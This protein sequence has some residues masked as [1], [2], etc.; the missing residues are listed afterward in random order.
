MFR[1]LL[2]DVEEPSFMD[3]KK[4]EKMNV[5]IDGEQQPFLD[6]LSHIFV[7]EE[8]EMTNIN[9]ENNITQPRAEQA[10]YMGAEL[11]QQS[12]LILD[13]EEVGSA[14]MING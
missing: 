13:E 7:L 2:D 11:Q 1:S 10:D 4:Q 3:S 6:E 9:D 12:T 8:A 5:Q 14:Q